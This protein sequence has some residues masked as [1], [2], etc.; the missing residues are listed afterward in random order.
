M[1]VSDYNDIVRQ[2]KNRL[3]RYAEK[4][5]RNRHTAVDVAQEAFMKLWENRH[6]V[7]PNK[8]PAWLY[9]TAYHHCLQLLRKERR[10][11]DVKALDH[12]TFEEPQP[13]LKK[14]L[15]DALDLLSEQ[16]RSILLLRDYEGYSYEEI[17]QILDVSGSQVKSNLFRARQRIKE[18]L[19]DLE[20]VI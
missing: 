14:I 8:V 12:F 2:Y 7:D 4:M 11:V 5:L 15:D 6:K 16:Q 17:G 13:D 1:T 19:R 3:C 20:F 9:T 18:Y 10:Y